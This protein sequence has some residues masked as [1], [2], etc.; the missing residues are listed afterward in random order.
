MRKLTL[1]PAAAVCAAALAACGGSSHTTTT[2]TTPTPAPVATTVAAKPTPDGMSRA[3]A[4]RA[5]LAAIAPANAALDAFKTKVKAMSASDTDWASAV[6]PSATA[7]AAAYNAANVKL[8][9]LAQSYPAA[10]ADLKALITAD[11]PMT[12][13][14]S[15]VVDSED[16]VGALAR[17]ART[18]SGAAQIVR[19]DLGLPAVA[20]S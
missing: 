8:A 17:D 19:A 18:S 5:Y 10:A 2:V 4:S 16:W 7:A 15:N 12:G 6:Q 1:I 3:Q 11:G 9:H 20:T 13:D 14:L